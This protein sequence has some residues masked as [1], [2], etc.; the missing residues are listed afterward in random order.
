MEEQRECRGWETGQQPLEKGLPQEKDTRGGERRKKWRA[1]T[2]TGGRR[3]ESRQRGGRRGRAE[4]EPGERR[5]GHME[6]GQIII[7]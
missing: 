1:N 4:C 6:G 7:V 3:T 5:R 2:K